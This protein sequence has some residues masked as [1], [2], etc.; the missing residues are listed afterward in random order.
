MAGRKGRYRK[1]SLLISQSHRYMLIHELSS[2]AVSTSRPGYADLGSSFLHQTDL[3]LA[4]LCNWYLR[5]VLLLRRLSVHFQ[6]RY[7]KDV[8]RD[9]NQVE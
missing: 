8:A 2:S 6:R 4:A 9:K 1:L 7:P 3:V 5:E